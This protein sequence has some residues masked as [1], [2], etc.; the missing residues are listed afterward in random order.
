MEAKIYFWL[1][2]SKVWLHC[3]W[4]FV[5]ENQRSQ[6][7][8]FKGM[9]TWSTSSKYASPHRVFTTSQEHHQLETTLS[10]YGLWRKLKCF[11]TNLLLFLF[12]HFYIYS[13]VYT[14]FGP[15]SPTI[16]ILTVTDIEFKKSSNPLF[17]SSIVQ[18]LP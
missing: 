18:N 11:K 9:A 14:V 6:N 12:C 2:V 13:H 17:I 10:V 3:F 7:V 1:I 4:I 8:S 15:P 16:K 5:R